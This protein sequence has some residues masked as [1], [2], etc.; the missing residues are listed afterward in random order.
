MN[1]LE[2]AHRFTTSL[3]LATPPIA[4]APSN[5]APP[6]VMTFEGDVPSA[7]TFW[8]RAEA[9]VFYAT[10]RQHFGCPIG[11]MVMGFPLPAPVEGELTRL[12]G[13]MVDG[14]YLGAREPE[15]IPSLQSK[16]AGVVYG[17][18]DRFPIDPAFILLWLTPRQGMFLAEAGGTT[19]WTHNG[20]SG[21]LGRP[22]CAALPVAASREAATVSFGCTGMRTF[23]E[24]AD[25]R[26]LA[27]I[28]GGK[29]PALATALTATMDA[30]RVM[31]AF[32]ES[33][34]A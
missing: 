28:P 21:I 17:P 32:Y 1:V 19:Y 25:D 34:K 29:A 14:G 8:R 6:G 12:V 13:M 5:A 31:Q 4:L 23:T 26:L 2:I 27:V 3:E 24:V 20:P 30:N 7:C 11:A 22:A 18:L 16:A 33:R 10:A 15:Q 9:G